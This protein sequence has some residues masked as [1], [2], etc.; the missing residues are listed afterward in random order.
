MAQI[1]KKN[2]IYRFALCS[3]AV[4]N[5]VMLTCGEVH[6]DRLAG[7]VLTL[8]LLLL[9]NLASCCHCCAVAN[10]TIAVCQCDANKP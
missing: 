10:A 1:K 4:A 7:S 9:A 2:H 8:L 5:G 3:R 6:L